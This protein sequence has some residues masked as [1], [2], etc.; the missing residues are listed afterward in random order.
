MDVENAKL[1]ERVQ[2]FAIVICFDHLAIKG[3]NLGFKISSK[4]SFMQRV[5]EI[6]NC[7]A[8]QLSNS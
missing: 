1:F 6:V 7:E 4:A 8:D 3:K 5:I 2:R